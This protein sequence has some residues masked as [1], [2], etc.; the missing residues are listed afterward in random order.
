MVELR[1]HQKRV[2]DQL[3]TGAILQ[4]GVGS[5]KSMTAL[6]HYYVKELE[7]S[8]DPF[9]LPKKS[10]PLYIITTAKKRDSLDWDR[11]LARYLLSKNPDVSVNG[12]KVVIDSW[13]NIEKYV[14]VKDAFFIFDEQRLV[15]SGTWAKTFIKITKN[16]NRWMVLT[17]TPGDV[18]MDYAAIFI[19][20]GFYKNKTAFTVQHVV[21]SRFS[22]YPKISHYVNTEE[23]IKNRN[24]I[25]VQMPYKSKANRIYKALAADH[26]KVAMETI[27]KKR[28][29]IFTNKPI[30]QAGELTAA[31]RRLVNSDPSRLNLLKEIHDKHPRLIVFYNFNYELYL[32]RDFLDANSIRYS[33]WNGHRHECIPEEDSWIYLVQYTAGAESWE[34]ITTNAIFFHSQN[35]SYKIK[36]QSEGRIDRMNTTFTDLYYYYAISDSAIDRSIGASLALKRDFNEREYESQFA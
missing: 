6:G 7:G 23:L 34:C 29:N 2:L 15:G 13:N 9:S 35:Y 28:W 30:R 24:S 26:D 33:E 4:G 11:E 3:K 32:L 20:N 8:L 12:T 21:F 19:A 16:N 1:E 31:Q 5:G 10:V 36:V 22:N 14:D 25:L 27:V 18:W 17:A